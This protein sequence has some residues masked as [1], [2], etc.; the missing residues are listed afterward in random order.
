[1]NGCV[2]GK[3]ISIPIPNCVFC[4]N[5]FQYP[6]IT[7]L[8]VVLGLKESAPV[9]EAS[10]QEAENALAPLMESDGEEEAAAAAAA[11]AALIGTGG[12][13]GGGAGNRGLIVRTM[14]TFFSNP[15]NNLSMR[16]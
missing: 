13:G 12:G 10:P 7:I 2:D 4:C 11:R 6:S 16:L 3:S 9:V 14:R 5:N 1:M 8:P 15:R